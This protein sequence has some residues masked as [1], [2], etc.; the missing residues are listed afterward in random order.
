[1]ATV[2]SVAKFDEPNKSWEEVG[3]SAAVRGREDE[4]PYLTRSL[5]N[6]EPAQRT[7]VEWLVNGPNGGHV[8]WFNWTQIIRHSFAETRTRVADAT[9]EWEVAKAKMLHSHLRDIEASI[10]HGR[11]YRQISYHFDADTGEWYPMESRGMGGARF[12]LRRKPAADDHISLRILRDCA[13]R[14]T[15]GPDFDCR[16]GEYISEISLVVRPAVLAVAA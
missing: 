15:T 10:E 1:M 8:C 7:K 13:F 5:A 9:N 4:F 2:I 12:Y 11:L 3:L 16:Q 14:D 6:A